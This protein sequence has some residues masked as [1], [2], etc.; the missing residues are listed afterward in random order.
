MKKKLP[1]QNKSKR[2]AEQPLPNPSKCRMP[3]VIIYKSKRTEQQPQATSVH[4]TNQTSISN[5]T[6]NQP[7]VII[8]K[9]KTLEEREQSLS[10]TN[11]MKRK[12]QEPLIYDEATHLHS[13]RQSSIIAANQAEENKENDTIFTFTPIVQIPTRKRPLTINKR[14]EYPSPRK[15][16]KITTNNEA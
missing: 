15:K 7:K 1:K 9:K 2:K 5:S 14:K 10:R 16:P 4:D 13:Q 12:R 3:R 6:R 11:L 8:Y